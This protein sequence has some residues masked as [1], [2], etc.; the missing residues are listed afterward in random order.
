MFFDHLFCLLIFLL[1]SRHHSNSS[2]DESFITVWWA[3]KRG[4][5]IKEG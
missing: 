4:N 5:K 3:K 1:F 2:K